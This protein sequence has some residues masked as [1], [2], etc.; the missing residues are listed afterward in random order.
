MAGTRKYVRIPHKDL[1]D[2]F[3]LDG[4]PGKNVYFL[5]YRVSNEAGTSFSKW[6]QEFEV[7]S[8][9]S[10]KK[11][12]IN[13]TDPLDNEASY[14]VTGLVSVASGILTAT[15]NVKDL[16]DSKTIFQNK[17][18]VYIRTYTNNAP[19][20]WT[21]AQEVLAT[22]FQ[23]KL[24]S[25]VQNKADVAILVPTYRG[26]DAE[27]GLGTESPLTLYPESVVW[28]HEG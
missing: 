6:S 18:H 19:N 14:R 12:L 25:D 10:S 9:M 26:L 28:Y 4:N 3:Y 21:F 27:P 20:Q 13:E 8:G 23:T 16:I 2:L 22:S 15:W 5:R 1:P 17:F 7:D 24:P 11:F